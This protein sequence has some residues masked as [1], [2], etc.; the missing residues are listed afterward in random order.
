MRNEEK[1]YKQ[2][3]ENREC[4]LH[5]NFVIRIHDTPLGLELSRY[6][7]FEDRK[8]FSPTYLANPIRG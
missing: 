2:G 1:G 8:W 3:A 4:G 6:W 7:M 5:K